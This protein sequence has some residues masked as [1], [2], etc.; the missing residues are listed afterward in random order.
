MLDELRERSLAV[1]ESIAHWVQ[2]QVAVAATSKQDSR[3]MGSVRMLPISVVIG[4]RGE[5]LYE[6]S[7]SFMCKNRAA[8]RGFQPAAYGVVYH[9]VG[10]FRSKIA[11]EQAFSEALTTYRKRATPDTKHAQYG[12]RSCRK[13]YLLRSTNVPA[14]LPC[15][16]CRREVQ[17]NALQGEVRCVTMDDEFLDRRP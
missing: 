7:P 13:H 15:E 11:A 9:Y 1:I 2:E 5:R 12:V 17:G 10:V 8:Q 3:K 14:D 4:L 16:Q 6:A